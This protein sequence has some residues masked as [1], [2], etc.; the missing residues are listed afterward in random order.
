MTSRL[1]QFLRSETALGLALSLFAFA[2]YLTTVSSSTGWED[3]GEIAA[4]VHTLGILHPTGYPLFTLM[5]RAFSMLPLGDLRVIAQLNLLGAILTAA[6]VFFFY[7]FLRMA[8]SAEGLWPHAAKNPVARDAFAGRCA[9]ASAALV[10]AFSR[11]FWSEATTVEVYALHLV[12]LSLVSWLFLKALAPSTARRDGIGGGRTWLL[13]AYALGL[14]FT[15]HMMTVLLAPA[16]LGLD[17]KR[18]GSWRNAWKGIAGAALPFAAGLSVYL[19]LPVRASAGPLLN[20][21][22]P[23]TPGAFWRHVSAHQFRDFMFSSWEVARAKFLRTFAELPADFGYVPLLVGAAGL[24]ILW[25]RNRGLLLF[26]S[27]LFMAC[28]VYEVNY[29]FND[30]NFRLQAWFAI[31]IW[32]AVALKT[33]LEASSTGA[34]RAAL[35]LAVALPLFPLALNYS[36]E[37]KSRD[38]AAE[39]FARNML[40]SVAPG[41]IL[42]SREYKTFTGPALY[43]QAVEGLR[44]DVTSLHLDLLGKPWFYSYLDHVDPGLLNGLRR[45]V[46]FYADEYGRHDHGRTAGESVRGMH[47]ELVLAILWKDYPRR[48]VYVTQ[49]TFLKDDVTPVPEGLAYRLYKE[50]AP[51]VS[52]FRNLS[53]RPVVHRD[54]LS[55]AVLSDYARAYTNQGLYR[56]VILGD[57]ALG[58]RFLREALRFEPGFAPAIQWLQKLQAGR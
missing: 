4:G 43:L 18:A 50:P 57:T 35:A 56:G 30:P 20:W 10:L 45:E 28:L 47:E 27:L 44:P 53:I 25:R 31:A 54:S 36:Q 32:A 5:G 14:S 48:P 12:F 55:R 49:N 2:V 7:R 1:R 16:F 34:R 9:A 37:D 21:G 13:F 42:Y 46:A 52:P 23:S 24:W 29:N 58:V 6:S 26:S 8:L 41:A 38:Y 3:S 22:D 17:F 51:P 15:N 33:G 39:D 40:E 19:Y 11:V